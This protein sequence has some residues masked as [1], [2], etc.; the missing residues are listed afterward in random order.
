MVFLSEHV[1]QY[2]HSSSKSL[3]KVGGA[4]FR[5]CESSLEV[6]K[7]SLQLNV[8]NLRPDQVTQVSTNLVQQKQS[9][10]LLSRRMGKMNWNPQS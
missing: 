9:D 5:I 3:L 7:L 6:D 10:I 8:S 2:P 1:T 4:V